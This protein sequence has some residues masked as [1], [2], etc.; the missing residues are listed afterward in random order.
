[1]QDAI[2]T[3][4]IIASVLLAVW[5][6][7]VLIAVLRAST[8]WAGRDK[9]RGEGGALALPSSNNDFRSDD[10]DRYAQPQFVEVPLTSVAATRPMSPAP[11]YTPTKEVEIPA[12]DYQDS[13]LGY[14]G[15][16]TYQETRVSRVDSKRGS[17]WDE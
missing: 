4:A 17:I 12:E 10:Q 7:V 9:V 15:R 3:E 13:K 14:A 6:L 5:F 8:L 1:V 11:K 2:R 16:R